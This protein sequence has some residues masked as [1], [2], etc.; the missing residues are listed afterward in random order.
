MGWRKSRLPTQVLREKQ[1][2]EP[3]EEVFQVRCIWGERFE[4]GSWLWGTQLLVVLAPGR[5]RFYASSDGKVIS[6]GFSARW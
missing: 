4:E 1:H 6:D 2:A 5:S 3:M